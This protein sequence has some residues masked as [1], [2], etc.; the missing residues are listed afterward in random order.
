MSFSV[1]LRGLGCLKSSF[2]VSV[3]LNFSSTSSLNLTLLFLV[4]GSFAG[5]TTLLTSTCL[6][7]AVRILYVS[8]SPAFLLKPTKYP[9]FSF[10]FG[11]DVSGSKYKTGWNQL[12]CKMC[13][14][15][16]SLLK[17]DF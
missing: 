14:I 7:S 6:W 4:F 11:C 3:L 5:L 2:W 13:D 15:P 16:L 12:N 8:A 17:P 9:G 1:G 10:V